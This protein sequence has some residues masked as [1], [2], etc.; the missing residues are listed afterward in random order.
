MGVGFRTYC[1]AAQA[2]G[3]VLVCV[4]EAK[5][6]ASSGTP[7]QGRKRVRIFPFLWAQSPLHAIRKLTR[8]CLRQLGTHILS[9]IRCSVDVLQECGFRVTL[10]AG[11]CLV[12]IVLACV[13]FLVEA[14]GI[15]VVWW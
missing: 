11:R 10:G 4:C 7:R 2:R 1:F 15:S 8:H 5:R 3:V 9:G 14:V 6:K 12:Y 13:I